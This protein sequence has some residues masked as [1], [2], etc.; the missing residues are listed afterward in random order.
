MEPTSNLQLFF[1]ELFYLQ[2]SAKISLTAHK[3]QKL[4]N[5]LEN[6]GNTSR[7]QRAE[8]QIEWKF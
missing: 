3:R 2:Q 8:V 7:I 1:E 5:I 4:F 6:I